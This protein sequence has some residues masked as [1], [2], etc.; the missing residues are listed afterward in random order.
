[1]LSTK[2]IK[3]LYF[4]FLLLSFFGCSKDEEEQPTPS[5]SLTAEQAYFLEVSLQNE[6]GSSPNVIKKWTNDIKLFLPDTNYT[7]LNKELYN[8]IAE[9][10][11]LSTTTK[12]YRIDNQAEANFIVYFGS[13]TAYAEKYEP[14]AAN[15]I[16]NNF[17]L[18]WIYW[19]T[20]YEIYKGSIYVDVFRTTQ[21]DC[22][23]HLLREELTQGLGLLN[24]SFRYPESIFYQGWTCTTSYAEID[25]KMIQY[26]LNP[27]IK[28][29]M[30]R[31]RVI[32]IL[33]QL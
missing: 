20:G 29:G 4:A 7:I 11:N 5:D 24:D 21:Q 8:I 30:T 9:L 19:N 10:N 15:Y 22:Q 28:P 31:T 1:M 23:R 33:K 13:G 3:F 12:I 25:K 27:L 14:N 17:G 32:E 6:F 16:N 2:Y 18:V 26:H